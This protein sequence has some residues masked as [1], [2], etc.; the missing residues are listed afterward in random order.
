MPMIAFIGVRISWLMAARKELLAWFARL[1]RLARFA[2]LGEQLGVVDGDRGLLRQPDQ[3]VEIGLSERTVFRACA[4][5]G[6]HAVDAARDR[7]AAR[8]S[9]APPRSRRAGDLD[10]A[11]VGL[12]TSLM[13]S[14]RASAA[15]VPMIPRPS[16]TVIA[17]TCS[18]VLPTA[19]VARKF[20][21][22]ASG[23]NTARG[24]SVEQV[25]RLR[26]D[27]LEKRVQVQRR[28]D[29]ST[30]VGER[31]HLGRASL[32]LAVQQGVLDGTADVRRERRQQPHVRLAEAAGLGDALDADG[33]DG[34]VAGDDRYAQVRPSGGADALC[35]DLVEVRLLVQEKRLARQD[36]AST[37]GP[38][39]GAASP[40]APC[41]PFSTWYGNSIMSGCR[42]DAAP[43]TR[44]PP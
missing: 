14:G 10:R 11:R 44:C 9:A 4:P 2:R 29:L 23:R 43:R 3:E 34:L 30:D 40:A 41:T 21:P 1:C 35:C 18:A 19:A 39:R 38:R 36:D 5:D 37:S 15:S 24:C 32:R 42:I 31:R 8:P 25:V 22:S 6:H 17:L 7:S 27:A 28:G 12:V 33:A 13:T 20:W 16:T 26:H